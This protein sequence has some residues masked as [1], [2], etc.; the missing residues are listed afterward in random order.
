MNTPLL[1][2]VDVC[3]TYTLSRGLLRPSAEVRAVN[4]VSLAVKGGETLGL[5]GE[6]GCGKSTL[7]RLLNLLEAPTSGTIRIGGKDTRTLD[8][9]AR[10]QMRRRIQMVFQDPYSSL[11]PRRTVG[12]TIGEPLE[13][14]AIGNPPARAQA[15]AELLESVGL[16]PSAANDY[17]HEFSGGQ[18]QRIAIARALALVPDVIIADEPVSALDVSVQAQILN[19]LQS[20]RESSGLTMVFVSHDLSVV[21]HVSD[22]IAVMYLGEIM[23]IA[24]NQTLFSGPL[25][26]YTQ[27]LI[28]S[29]P[30]RHPRYRRQKTL[31]DGDIPSPSR[32]PSGC[33]FHT[34]CP[35]AE[36][37]CSEHR[38]APV[39]VG[40]GHFLACHVVARGEMDGAME[41]A[42][43]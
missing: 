11:N 38:P 1:E 22:R 20:L 39:E 7:S 15:V 12:A 36:P 30:P 24:P 16:Q 23:E 10:H 42:N 5:V 25:H 2:L 4:G 3:K 31:L 29:A 32:P 28:A 41:A 34:R 21:R 14:F 33:P 6:S 13:N 43:G 19:L 35:I 8:K 37:G 18:R 40:P 26:P 17:P 27:A 9:A